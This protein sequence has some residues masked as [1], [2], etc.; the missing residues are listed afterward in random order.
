MNKGVVGNGGEVEIGIETN[1]AEEYE[2]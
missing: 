2:A 1:G